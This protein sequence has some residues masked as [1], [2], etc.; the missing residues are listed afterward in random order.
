MLTII[1]TGIAITVFFGILLNY[2]FTKLKQHKSHYKE[3]FSTLY[4]PI[5]IK[6]QHIKRTYGFFESQPYV[7]REHRIKQSNKV[8]DS[9]SLADEIMEVL[10]LNEHFMSKKM[11]ELYFN[12]HSKNKEYNDLNTSTINEEHKDFLTAKL[13]YEINAQKLILMDTYFKEMQQTALKADLLYPELKDMLQFYSHFTNHILKN[14][15]ILVL[16][17]SAS[18]K[19]SQRKTNM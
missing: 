4:S 10:A 3:M 17:T 11:M 15:L 1:L 12:I 18:L 9:I 13:S 5:I 16:P 7:I 19:A 8:T 2:Y 14:E 6:A